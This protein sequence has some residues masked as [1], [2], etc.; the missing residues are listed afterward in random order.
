MITVL[1]SWNLKRATQSFG[2][3]FAL[4]ELN[5]V[6]EHE[7]AINDTAFCRAEYFHFLEAQTLKYIV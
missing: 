2:Q 1:A 3:E 6:C 4:G 5:I 7:A